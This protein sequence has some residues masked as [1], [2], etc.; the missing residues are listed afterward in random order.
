MVA[1]V[2]ER[3]RGIV[4]NCLCPSAPT[5][6]ADILERLCDPSGGPLVKDEKGEEVAEFVQWLAPFRV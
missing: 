4:R 3:L 1:R 6:M 5:T 2:E